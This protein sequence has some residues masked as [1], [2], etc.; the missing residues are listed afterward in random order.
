MTRQRLT[1]RQA[2]ALLLVAAD[3]PIHKVASV[4][5]IAESTLYA[6]LDAAGRKLGTHSRK[7]SIE[8]ARIWWAKRRSR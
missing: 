8:L 1:P 6:H 5:G 3:V 4:M 7:A 2:E